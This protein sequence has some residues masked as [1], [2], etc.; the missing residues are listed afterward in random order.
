MRIYDYSHRLRARGLGMSDS[1]VAARTS[2][3]DRVAQVLSR[4]EYRRAAGTELEAIFRLRYDAYRREGAIDERPHKWLDDKFDDDVNAH[5]IGIYID[6]TL[7]SALRVHV[8]SA[9]HCSSPA[10]D[11]FPDVLV[12][13]LDRGK[14]IID[15]NRFVVDFASSRLYP[16]LPFI[17]LRL[18][19]IAA[20]HFGADLVTATVRRE[21]QAFYR[22][23]LLMTP[24]CPPRPYPTLTKHLGLMI[25]DFHEAGDA[26]L[27]RR[28]FYGSTAAERNHIFGERVATPAAQPVP[29]GLAWN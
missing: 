8:A 21:H 3:S 25:V 19:F 18:P 6:G 20:G 22:R 1:G 2:V 9:E 10:V 26:V 27:R 28:P 17:T 29:T 12:D 13:E 14:I 24:V 7:A 4:V 16:E 15:P 5:Q 11:N 23:E